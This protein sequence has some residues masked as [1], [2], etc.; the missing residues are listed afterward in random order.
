M[1]TSRPLVYAGSAAACSRQLAPALELG[2][3]RLGELEVARLD[4]AG[5]LV[6]RDDHAGRV[7]LRLDQLQPGGGGAVA[8]EAFPVAEHHR[9]DQHAEFVDQ[10]VLPQR[11]Q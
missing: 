7:G 6:I 9:E 10:S 2:L 5:R 3:T 8:E 11:L 4:L 1:A